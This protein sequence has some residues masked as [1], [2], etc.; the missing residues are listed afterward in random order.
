MTRASAFRGVF[1][2]VWFAAAL[3]A[4]SPEPW[5]S[6]DRGETEAALPQLRLRAATALVELGLAES[7]DRRQT[8]ADQAVQLAE[9]LGG[10]IEPAAR[11]LAAWARGNDA[12]AR[13]FLEQAVAFPEAQPRLWRLL[14]DIARR[15]GRN[16]DAL[17]AYERLLAAVPGHPMALV[18]V[19]DLHRQ[20]GRLDRAFNAYNHA[21]GEDGK[22]LAA[23]LGRASVAVWLGD[24]EGA[25]RD[26]RAVLEKA[27]G[28]ERWWAL[29]GIFYLRALEGRPQE[30][31]PEAEAALE[32]WA[33]ANRPDMMAATTNAVARVLLELADP[34]SG[35]AWYRR[36]GEIV[37][38]STLPEE[39]KVLWRVRELH[40]LARAAAKRGDLKLARK[41]AADA[42]RLMDADPKNADHY[43]WISPYLEGYLRLYEKNYE[44]AIEELL[45]SDTERAG[46]RLLIAE[47]YFRKKDRQNARM[48][49][50]KALEAVTGL[51]PESVIAGPAA[52][53]W[54]EKNPG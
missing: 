37:A 1:S 31:L 6:V 35:E 26:L 32:V 5:W 3:G 54:L 53:A 17:A 25:E 4:Q 2:I 27:E 40:G 43:A 36:G 29:M 47:A 21:V 42:K 44:G 16:E 49:Y 7:S 19:G 28:S 38:A 8:V 45:K 13:T 39:D 12:E 46:I 22:P 52:R 9:G 41:R 51:D 48:W 30:G 50:R 23:R 11:G 14:G 24:R 10:W 18:A 20:A 34:A 15:Q 33:K